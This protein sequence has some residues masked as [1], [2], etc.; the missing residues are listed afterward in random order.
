MDSKQ[1]NSA[2][3]MN[4]MCGAGEKSPKAGGVMRSRRLTALRA[5]AGGAEAQVGYIAYFAAALSCAAVIKL[6][7]YVRACSR[8]GEN[9]VNNI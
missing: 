3:A 2:R 1:I 4:T 7:I 6:R 8:H 9:H 5:A